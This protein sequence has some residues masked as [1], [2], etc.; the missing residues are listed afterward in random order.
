M[1]S[2]PRFA[3]VSLRGRPTNTLAMSGCGDLKNGSAT[4]A[5]IALRYLE[6]PAFLPQYKNPCWWHNSKDGTKVFRCLPYFY[7]AGFP[8]C[9][10]TDLYFR[11]QQHPF[12]VP[13]IQK[14]PHFLTRFM[15]KTGCS[16]QYKYTPASTRCNLEKYT[17]QFF[18]N[19]AN[20]IRKNK[21]PSNDNVFQDRWRAGQTKKERLRA[22]NPK[23]TVDGSASTAW[24]NRNWFRILE[25][26][27]CSEPRVGP[28]QVVTRMNPDVR[29]IMI[30]RDPT[31]RLYSDY[32]YFTREEEPTR[33]GFHDRVKAAIAAFQ[34]C[35][36][37]KPPS[38]CL[39][40]LTQVR[41][42][43]GLYHIFISD[44]L[45][46]LPRDHLLVLQSESY[47]TNVTAS[48]EQ[49][50]KFLD[51]REY[52]LSKEAL[53]R[54]SNLKEKNTTKKKSLVGDMLPETKVLLRRFYSEHNEK[55][56]QLLGDE[57]FAWRSK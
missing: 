56:A 3:G 19:S 41:L 1:Y 29:I 10:T 22:Q 42:H 46:V 9:G 33:Q 45:S 8:K 4:S 36:S 40:K 13:A 12:V 23:I 50:F 24:D 39:T 31:D 35:T 49:I 7:L 15:Y 34:S 6:P 16:K 2:A 37:H 51:L 17:T 28:A 54:I 43:I 44:W 20:I 14:E 18:E 5:H 47:R 26:Q 21:K 32:L 11:L 53:Q 38:L 48:L 57:R 52:P 55:L 30:L 25:N 27:G